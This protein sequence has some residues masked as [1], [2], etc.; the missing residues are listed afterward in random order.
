MDNPISTPQP[1]AG[2]PRRSAWAPAVQRT[3]GAMGDR[4]VS[5][6]AP[7]ARLQRLRPSEQARAI[8][9][10]VVAHRGL[11]SRTAI[12]GAPIAPTAATRMRLGLL[13]GADRAPQSAGP[14]SDSVTTINRLRSLQRKQFAP[15]VKTDFRKVFAILSGSVLHQFR[16]Y[17]GEPDN[18]A[19]Y[20]GQTTRTEQQ[21]IYLQEKARQAEND[22][23]GERASEI[24]EI[25]NDLDRCA[26]EDLRTLM[27]THGLAEPSSTRAPRRPSATTAQA[28]DWCKAR[29]QLMDIRDYFKNA[30]KS[31]DAAQFK[32]AVARMDVHLRDR[33][34]GLGSKRREELLPLKAGSASRSEQMYR[35]LEDT[36]RRTEAAGERLE[37][38]RLRRSMDTMNEN[39]RREL[40]SLTG[41]YGPLED[42]AAR[43]GLIEQ[44]A[45]VP[46]GSTA[47][48]AIARVTVAPPLQPVDPV[49]VPGSVP[50]PAPRRPETGAAEV[51][52]VTELLSQP[53]GPSSRVMPA[54]APRAPTAPAPEVPLAQRLAIVERFRSDEAVLNA[55]FT[56]GTGGAIALDWADMRTQRVF[57]DLGRLHGSAGDDP[58][59]AAALADI[60]W[61]GIEE[62]TGM[63]DLPS[64]SA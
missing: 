3:Q 39:A 29:R 36:V 4:R 34:R 44:Q 49:P 8:A 21:Y 16:K 30:G 51:P 56:L 45:P 48:T 12:A 17:G 61:G 63:M 47:A 20:D 55:V 50:P 35:I 57:N 22:G 28:I 5:E 33:F 14:V 15:E 41:K 11:S 27:E 59:A 24:R 52:T 64:L 13:G 31:D 58:A 2:S 37:A 54:Q 7:E 19:T 32:S 18:L 53:P 62:L 38:A 60:D 23:D 42:L 9:G 43:A 1:A 46:A 10:A 6:P 25:L 40:R 26:D